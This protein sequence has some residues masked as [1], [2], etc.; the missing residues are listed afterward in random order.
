MLYPRLQAGVHCEWGYAPAHDQEGGTMI[1]SR[2]TKLLGLAVVMGVLAVLMPA[3]PALAAV[4]R[5]SPHPRQAMGMAYDTADGRVVMFGGSGNGYLDD[6]WTWDGTDWTQ[7]HPAHAPHH[8]Y[9]AAMVYD[10][11]HRQV[12]LF[13]GFGNH[14]LGDTWTWDGTDWTQQHPAHAPSHRS[15]AG[16]A[17]DS[18]DGQVVLFGGYAGRGALHH[19]GTWTWDGTDWTLQHPAHEPRHR[20]GVGMAY[21]SADGQVVLFGGHNRRRYFGDTWTWDGTDWTQQSPV[22]SPAARFAHAMSAAAD[23]QVVLFSGVAGRFFDDTWTWDGTDWTQQSPVNSP[24][25]R[26]SHA[27]SVAAD[28]QVVLFGGA[29]VGRNGSTAAGDTWAWDGTDWTQRP[30]GSISVRSRSGSPGS[31]VFIHVWGFAAGEQVKI[32]FR[33][34]LH[35]RTI[36]TTIFTDGTGAEAAGATIPSS[37]T[38][39]TQHIKGVG[40]MSGQV[41]KTKFTVT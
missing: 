36:L 16:M 41:A 12:V 22:H 34:S 31:S 9:D 24:P 35:G 32:Y 7:Q 13:G 15:G 39:G 1:R 30:G 21:D 38:P 19:G 37:A 6:T 26:H 29:Y 18:A 33:D 20:S 23:G 14:Y 2:I 5:P 17:Y 8:R 3:A 40:V 11:A 27:M 4:H 10:A 28:G 25:A